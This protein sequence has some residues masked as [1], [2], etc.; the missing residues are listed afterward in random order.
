MRDSN[1]EAIAAL[2]NTRQQIVAR[3]GRCG[4]SCRGRD[5]W[6]RQRYTRTLRD[7]RVLE[8]A[9]VLADLG[10]GGELIELAT[11]RVRMPWADDP[12]PVRLTALIYV[13]NDLIGGLK[14]S[15][16]E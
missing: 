16:V 12:V 9:R 6:H 1:P 13:T 8:A 3:S 15:L 5:P 14:W 4:C 11:A 10:N 2:A 7:L